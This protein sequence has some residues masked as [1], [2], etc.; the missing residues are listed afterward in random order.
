M[1]NSPVTD[2]GLCIE[3]VTGKLVNVSNPDPLQID[4]GDI[5]W[6][7]SRIPRFAG[8]TI[9]AIPYNVAQHSVYVAELVMKLIDGE[10]E[11]PDTEGVLIPTKNK[12]TL[13]IHSLIHDGHEAYTGDIP[14][15]IKKIPELTQVLKLIEGR[16]DAAI[17][18][19]LGL[20]ELTLDEKK[21]IKLA[22]KI[23]Q[24]IEGYQFMPS[25][26]LKWNLPR[27]T[28][29]QLQQFPAPQAPQESYK[30]FMK[31]FEKRYGNM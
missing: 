18:K 21:L 25:R 19:T 16:L 28:L 9:T 13:F 17:H 12:N 29:L 20:P 10:I 27:T 24:A 11:I 6:A 2:F 5:A 22:D 15:P 26:G 1:D 14:S 3:T 8:H 4:I 31:N 30:I 7:L 23:A